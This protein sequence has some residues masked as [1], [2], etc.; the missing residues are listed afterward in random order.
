MTNADL[1]DV[2]ARIEWIEQQLR[3][4]APDLRRMVLLRYRLGWS[5]QEVAT[6][7]GLKTGAVDGRIRRAVEEL[8]QQAEW[9]L[10]RMNANEK[11]VAQ[12]RR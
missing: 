5:L 11:T 1:F 9:E 8:R 7:F 10:P 3:K 2:Q 12:F 4:L 6:K